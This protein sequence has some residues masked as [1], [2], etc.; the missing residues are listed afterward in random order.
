MTIDR[1]LDKTAIDWDSL[2]TLA[3]SYLVPTAFGVGL[4]KHPRSNEAPEELLGFLKALIDSNRKRNN[5]L[6]LQYKKL[7][8]WLGAENILPMKGIALLLN[9]AYQDHA[10]RIL[11]DIDILVPSDKL[12]H[13]ANLLKDQGYSIDSEAESEYLANP[14]HHH[15]P[16][17]IHSSFPSGVELHSQVTS[18]AGNQFLHAEELW[19]PTK[20]PSS[21]K[22]SI[23]HLYLHT[24]T[25]GY[26]ND[27]SF[28]KSALD[29][30]HSLDLAVL[31]NV[32]E[33]KIDYDF[34]EQRL[35]SYGYKDFLALH[36]S[37]NHILFSSIEENHDREIKI[38]AENYFRRATLIDKLKCNAPKLYFFLV[39]LLS[40]Y[41]KVT[42]LFLV[43]FKAYRLKYLPR[44]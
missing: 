24:L 10:V 39:S 40:N 11:S 37:L 29:L 4:L 20:T 1:Y 17:L 41:C 14:V 33:N 9:G 18:P 28:C 34:I 12:Y 3:D 5:D 2:V 30:R 38:K 15:Y 25:H 35:S 13:F 36:S 16:G 31:D 21:S 32:F 26:L 42:R 8:A 19:A 27:L 23:T 44:R 7:E 43:P 6:I 22:D